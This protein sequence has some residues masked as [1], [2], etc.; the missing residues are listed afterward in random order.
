ML[1]M[2]LLLVGLVII[3][4][5]A[6]YAIYL[7]RKVRAKAAEEKEQE[8]ALE[9]ENIDQRRR[10]NQSIQIIAQGALEDQLSLTEASIRIKVLLDSL[11]LESHITK[12]YD[13]FYVLALATDHIPILAQWKALS[14]KQQRVFE[15]QRVALEG[16]HNAAVVEAATRIKGQVF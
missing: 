14:N 2:G 13:A 10:I 9:K 7:Q 5:L 16:E 3:A 12:Q 11:G 6:A 15:K 4:V 8:E 1:L